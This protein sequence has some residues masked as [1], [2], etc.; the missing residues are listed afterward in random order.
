LGIALA[1]ANC[2]RFVGGAKQDRLIRLT[3]PMPLLRGIGRLKLLSGGSMRQGIVMTT[4]ATMR[5]Q[6]SA[7]RA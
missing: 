7:M 4:G 1:I 2:L 6:R 3:P 5:E